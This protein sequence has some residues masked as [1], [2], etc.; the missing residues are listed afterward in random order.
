MASKINCNFQPVNTLVTFTRWACIG[1]HHFPCSV[2]TTN[3]TTSSQSQLSS[4]QDKQ[5]LDQALNPSPSMYLT[6]SCLHVFVLSSESVKY[7]HGEAYKYMIKSP[8]DLG[9]VRFLL[10]LLQFFY[11]A[12]KIIHILLYIIA[13]CPYFC[14]TDNSGPAVLVIR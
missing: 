13:F 10:L 1:S 3:V 14:A 4:S 7:Y 11:E 6:S 9:K 12:S 8:T 2:F 5:L